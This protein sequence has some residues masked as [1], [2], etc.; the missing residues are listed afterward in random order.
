MVT[1][2]NGNPKATQRLAEHNMYYVPTVY[3]DDGDSVIAGGSTSQTLYGN[4]IVYA[5]GRDVH[6]LGLDI[7]LNWLGNETVEVIFT[8]VNNELINE[9]PDIPAAPGGVSEGTV[10]TEYQFTASTTDP[11]ANTVYFKW[12][13]GNGTESDWLGPY[14]SGETCEQTYQWAD[15]GTYDV[16]VKAMDEWDAESDWSPALSVDIAP[17]YMCGDAN[18]DD[19][20]NLL[21]ILHLISYIYGTPQGDP[22]D[23]M[24]AGDPNADGDINLLDILNLISYVYGS[25]PG[26]EPLC[27]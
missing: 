15:E 12:D 14:N 7:E 24:E 6:E 27:P 11:D 8:I 23:P 2:T 26:P 17:A 13:W 21:D 22:P 10:N 25:P 18:N 19:A 9:P 20:I 3:V 1:G 16:A 5:G 4:A